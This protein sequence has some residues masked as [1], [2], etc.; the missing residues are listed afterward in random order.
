MSN[1]LTFI[2]L[3]CI[4]NQIL[5]CIRYLY[6]K[7]SITYLRHRL[8]HLD[9]RVSL[10]RHCCL[11]RPVLYYRNYLR[12]W[13]SI[14]VMLSLPLI[15]AIDSVS[16]VITTS[17]SISTS[18]SFANSCNQWSSH[19]DYLWREYLFFIRFIVNLP[20]HFFTFHLMFTWCSLYFQERVAFSTDV[21]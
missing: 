4:T 5:W 19:F 10:D 12:S 14:I 2:A 9:S 13:F 11:L 3:Q 21:K 20:L 7:R 17:C 6:Y 15:P 8:Q 16:L 18:I 1:P